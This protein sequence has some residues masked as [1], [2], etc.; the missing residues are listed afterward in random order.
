[1]VPSEFK[2]SSAYPNPF[3]STVVLD[4]EIAE[5]EPV[6]F[7]ITNILGQLV[8]QQILLPTRAGKFQ[9]SWNGKDL[10]QKELPSGI[11]LYTI[12]SS[13]N[14]TSGKFTYLK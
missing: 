4:I 3:N 7:S 2:V 12:K 9:I 1:V 5:V 13:G 8:Y 11:Y 10:L 14:I 6:S